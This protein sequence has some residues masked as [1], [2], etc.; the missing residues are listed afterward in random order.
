MANYNLRLDDDVH[1]AL[2]ERDETMVDALNAAARQYLGLAEMDNK[3]ALN[4]RIDDLEQRIAEWEAQ[5]ARAQEN[6]SRLKEMRAVLVEQREEIEAQE[7]SWEEDLDAL[8][9]D[10]Q[11]S[12]QNMFAEHADVE[13]I[14][15]THDETPDGVLDALQQRAGERGLGMA[16]DRFKQELAQQVVAQGGDA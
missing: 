10:M 16:D 2:R 8:L 11:T 7:N 3:A 1:E 6:I 12:G 4:R 9:D 15:R 5:E 14:A 13:E